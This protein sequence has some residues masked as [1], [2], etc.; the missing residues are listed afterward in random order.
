MLS[1]GLLSKGTRSSRRYRK[2]AKRAVIVET[3]RNA[4]RDIP[5]LAVEGRA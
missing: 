5:N 2:S 1:A 3:E 4:K